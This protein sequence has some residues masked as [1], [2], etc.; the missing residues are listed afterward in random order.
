MYAS[1]V[2]AAAVNWNATD[3]TTYDTITIDASVVDDDLTD[4]PVY[5]DL[6]DLS[7][8]FWAATPAASSTVGA[9]IRIT[10]DAADTEMPRELVSASSTA[11]TGELHF[12]ADSISSTTDTVFRVY[13]N[14]T[15]TADYASTTTYGSQN[16]WSNDYVAVLHLEGTGATTTDSVGNYDFAYQGGTPTKS[17]TLPLGGYNLDGTGDYLTYD[18]AVF[19]EDKDPFTY[20]MWIN[21]DSLAGNQ[22]DQTALI[23]EYDEAGRTRNYWYLDDVGDKISF[24][25]YL[26]SGGAAQSDSSAVSLDTTYMLHTTK[27]SNQMSFYT[28]GE[29]VGSPVSH[30]ETYSSSAPTKTWIGHRDDGANLYE[31]DG[32]ID[33][34]RIASSSRSS[35]WISAEYTNQATT[36]DFYKVNAITL[37][38]TSSAS[39]AS[40]TSCSPSIPA[41]A[42][43]GDLMLVFGNSSI[44][45]VQ[46]IWDD[47]GGGGNG[48]TQ[49]D[50]QLGVSGVDRESAIYYK[51]HD[52]SESNPTFTLGITSRNISCGMSVYRGVDQNS[53]FDVTY[54]S[55]SHYSQG[56]NNPV[57]D[58]PDITTVTDEAM[59]VIFMG[60]GGSGITTGG[61]PDGYT[62]TQSLV[63]GATYSNR[64]IF[65]ALKVV[66]TAGVET[67]GVWTHATTSSGPETQQFTLALRPDQGEWNTNNWTQYDVITI[68]VNNID[69]ALNNFP[70]YVD[71]SDLSSAFWGAVSD[72]GGDIRVTTNETNPTE[73]PR[74]VV[75]ASTTAETGELHFKADRISATIDTSFRIYYN[76]TSTDYASTTTFGAQN[77]WSNDYA[78]VWHMDDDP[79]DGANTLFD[80]TVNAYNGTS[81]G[82][83][84]SDDVITGKVGNAYQFDGTDDYVKISSSPI[85]T[86]AN[87]VSGWIWIDLSKA[88]H[89]IM[90]TVTSGVRA[91]NPHFLLQENSGPL[92]SY[93]QTTGYDEFGS[94]STGSWEHF[95]VART[96]SNETAYLNGAEVINRSISS[97]GVNVEFNIGV[98][99]DN[100]FDGRIDNIR[101]STSTRT[102][103]WISAEYINQSTTTDFYTLSTGTGSSTIDNN[104]AGQV[105]DAFSFQNKTDEALYAFKITPNSGTAT[106]TQ[107]RFTLKG[108]QKIDISDFSNLRIYE[109]VNDDAAY[110]GGDTQVASAGVMTLDH[111][112]DNQQGDIVFTNN[113]S[114]T[115]ATNFILVADWNAPPR[116]SQLTL[117]LVSDGVYASDS[118]GAVIVDGSVSSVQHNRSTGGGGGS[119]TPVGGAPPEGD[120]DVGGG[121]NEGGE[122]IGDDPNFKLPTTNSGTW[123]NPGN[124]YDD[125][126]GTY[127]TDNSGATNNYSD[128]DF[129]VGSGNTI[130]GIAVQLE[131]SGT[132]AAGDIGVELSWDGGTSWTSSGNVT[133]TLTTTDAVATIGGPSDTWGR[134][135]IDSEFSNANFAVRLTGNPSSN[136]VQVDA[137][138]VRIYHQAG[139]GGGGGGGAI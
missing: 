129:S 56:S 133:P 16:V 97:D 95:S 96:S 25:Q 94:I 136:T 8:A 22:A 115:S 110:D 15:T 131:I 45:N 86:T 20:Q 31:I 138:Q 26:P 7:A 5:V 109:D 92:R 99:Y 114:I 39:S 28:N 73:L 37:V 85:D 118:N 35:S 75:S 139:G 59:V 120:G 60:A 34:V 76:G 62:L 53:P 17:A 27:S 19:G 125:T 122:L 41:G 107:M 78:A 98:G 54:S 42:Q 32:D 103:S 112:Y 88:N 126:D 134:S 3:W 43:S 89:G 100:Y 132:T 135:W 113:F 130:E 80:S 67:I 71:L 9:D 69:E 123:T 90:E 119:S 1:P 58:Q 61:A 66:S 47:D 65:A 57:P 102:S 128:H 24:D 50:Y 91:G 51:M 87:S 64:Q 84:T 52:G 105:S 55:G 79:T 6:A 21:A 29:I 81:S 12:K 82:T 40:V 36:A 116:G 77:V 46:D 11:E 49:L 93:I 121:T 101:I 14:G 83:M 68:D 38:A 48:W 72:G 106:V 4:F 111:G 117:E 127:A 104:D 63:P 33:E 13:Y 70:V 23:G 2:L 10:N 74:E 44:N 30:S 108:A 124:A 137:I 18:G